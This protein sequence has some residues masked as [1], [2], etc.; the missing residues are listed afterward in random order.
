MYIHTPHMGVHVYTNT[1][2]KIKLSVWL[3]ESGLKQCPSLCEKACSTQ[4]SSFKR[5]CYVCVC[6]NNQK[7]KKFFL[8]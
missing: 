1:K 5:V 4:P 8:L 2:Q 7:K 3:M 6:L